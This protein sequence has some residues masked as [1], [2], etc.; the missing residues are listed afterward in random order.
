MPS[1]RPWV[2]AWLLLLAAAPT[3]AADA[4][5]Q[6]WAP[7]PPPSFALRGLDGRTVDLAALRGK[8]VL[9]N[10][11]ATWCAPCVEEL[12]SLQHL[13]LEFGDELEIV[14]VNLQ[15]GE[16]RI[17]AF[18]E[19]SSIDLTIVRDTDG[20]V[21]RAWGVRLFPT[22]IVIDAH[23]T[24]RWIARGALDWMAPPVLAR[25]RALRADQAAEDTGPGA[26][27]QGPPASR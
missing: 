25:L 19:R 23:G 10:F 27:A 17:R 13:R 4:V 8:L 26:P 16:P 15:E 9:V 2:L 18:L 3:L 5:L 21:A 6:P 14:A 22:S 1:A 24:P 12:P 11:W 7:P 20:A